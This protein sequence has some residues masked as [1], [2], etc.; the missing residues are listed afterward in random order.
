M[1]SDRKIG[2]WWAKYVN[3]CPIWR[4]EALPDP[5]FKQRLLAEKL[6]IE[7]RRDLLCLCTPKTSDKPRELL[8]ARFWEIVG[9]I[10]TPYAPYALQGP[11]A[12]NTHFGDWSVPR[13]VW[14]ATTRSRTRIALLDDTELVVDRENALFTSSAAIETLITPSGCKLQVEVPESAL[15]RLR[16]RHMRSQPDL[17]MA[18]L[19][20]AKF[21]LDRLEALS[22]SHYRPAKF[23]KLADWCAQLDRPEIAA[24]LRAGRTP[25]RKPT[26][27]TA[28]PSLI[29][30]AR[31]GQ[32]AYVTR[33]LDHLQLLRD[34]LGEHLECRFDGGL[35]LDRVLAIAEQEK[36][37]DT[38]H[39]STIEGY[40]VSPHEI[41][42]LIG[43][44]TPPP[45]GESREQI[46]RRMALLGYFAAH[47]FT[48]Q[49]VAGLFGRERVLTERLA[50]DLHAQLFKPSVDACLL[51]APSLRSYRT[52]PV[53]IRNS[54]FV[55]PN[56][57]KLGE[58]MQSAIEF[59]NDID[60]FSARAVLIHYAFVTIHPYTDGNGRT[61]RLLMN[62]VLATSG[63]PWVTI[64][65]EDRDVYFRA[66][67]QAQC[68]S[69][70]DGLISLF[71]R[72]FSEPTRRR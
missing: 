42:V 11:T 48:L 72:Y 70:F 33:L 52:I 18:F 63:A 69:K 65:I 23:K 56:W 14:V 59:I 51:T 30:P 5:S 46:E 16:L 54:R 20:S 2:D 38:Y 58:L 29:A 36:K 44:T 50:Q 28:P 45:S 31:L 8:L 34:A 13:S 67:Q 25:P 15:I 12:L 19:K 22:Q 3:E 37:S 66:L 71:S 6:A 17:V 26:T 49:Q 39:S 55:P 53:Y 68:D 60:E 27:I 9:A 32:P 4:T 35:V 24:V 40:R 21:D 7:I 62:F 10:L 47:H 43:G 57:Q 64:R 61:A 1:I 41:D